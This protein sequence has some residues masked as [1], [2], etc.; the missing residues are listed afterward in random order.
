MLVV[1]SVK[2]TLRLVIALRL[3][4]DVLEYLIPH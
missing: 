2:V 1:L 3:V 4:L